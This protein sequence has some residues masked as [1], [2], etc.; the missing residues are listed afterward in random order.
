MKSFIAIVLIAALAGSLS[1]GFGSMNQ[2]SPATATPANAAPPTAPGPATPADPASV[3]RAAALLA[4]VARAYQEAPALTDSMVIDFEAGP[5][6]DTHKIHVSFSRD[7]GGWSVVNGLGATVAV[8]LYRDGN[9]VFSLAGPLLPGDKA[10]LTSGP[11]AARDVVPDDLP[12][13]ERLR[14]LVLNQPAGSYLAVLERSPFWDP[15][16][17]SVAERGSFHL[18]IGWP[19]G[20]P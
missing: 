13:S 14:H 16:L 3:E 19:D 11:L 9:T 1:L 15:G 8:L 18:V 10:I 17:S 7:A 20:Q 6:R 4:K 5:T 12:I 2:Q